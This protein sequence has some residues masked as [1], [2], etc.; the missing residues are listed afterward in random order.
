MKGIIFSIL[1]Q[2]QQLKKFPIWDYSPLLLRLLVIPT[3]SLH[4]KYNK[5]ENFGIENQ[6]LLNILDIY[7]GFEK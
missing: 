4:K 3:T 5:I 2:S 6:K 7:S 1:F